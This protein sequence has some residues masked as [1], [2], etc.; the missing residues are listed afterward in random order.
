LEK[1]EKSSDIHTFFLKTCFKN[2]IQL[3]R[4]EKFRFNKSNNKDLE[5]FVKRDDLIHKYISGNK[6]RKLNQNIFSFYKNK[7]KKLVTFGGAFSNHLLAT[8][9]LCNE[10]SIDCVGIVRG[11][12]LNV[13]SNGILK[14]CS[15]LGMQLNF[16]SRSSFSKQKKMNGF[17]FHDGIPTWFVPE[18]G[19]NL[20]GIEGCK[21]IVSENEE[22]FDYYVVAQGTTTTS[23]GIALALPP[24]AKIIVVPVLKGFNSKSEMKSVLNNVDLWNV[25]KD[26]I[27]VL[28]DFH[29]GGYAKST[30]EL[31][32]FIS[33]INQLNEMQ[34]EEVYTGKALYALNNY[35]E[36]NV[37]KNK[38]VLFI[39]TGGI[40]TDKN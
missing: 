25:I 39:H 27:I 2:F 19:A 40:F 20:E 18:G 24:S 4:I 11:E 9:A 13:N 28:D 12:E 38:K 36:K 30:N 37:V 21:E 15:S 5:L 26:K 17:V 1:E 8:A 14:K 23:I 29:F 31:R 34:I 6:I 35:M 16:V 22:I 32:E 7:C 10:L 33:E 3:S